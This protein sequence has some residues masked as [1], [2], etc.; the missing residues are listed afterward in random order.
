MRLNRYHWSS[1]YAFELSDRPVLATRVA[2]DRVESPDDHHD[3]RDPLDGRSDPVVEPVDR[4][5]DPLERPHALGRL[6]SPE[7]LPRLCQLP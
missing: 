2:G 3:Q 1:R 6:C 5:T 4:G 7:V